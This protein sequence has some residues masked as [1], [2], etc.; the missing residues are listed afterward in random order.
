MTAGVPPAGPPEAGSAVVDASALVDLLAGTDRAAAVAARLRGTSLHAPAHLDA[1]VLSALG[2]LHRAGSMSTEATAAACDRLVRAPVNRHLL[3][4]L[5]P[6]AWKLHG[7]LRL[8]DA[9]Y[10]ALGERLAVPVLT[11][12]LRLARASPRAEG[13]DAG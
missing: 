10:V 11:T 1:E 6:D 2:R 7:S 4:D 12:D 5:V 3:T 13:I 8:A 9:L